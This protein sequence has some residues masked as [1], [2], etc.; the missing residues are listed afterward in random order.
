MYNLIFIKF[1]LISYILPF[2]GRSYYFVKFPGNDFV[3]QSA[4]ETIFIGFLIYLMI[5]LIRFIVFFIVSIVLLFHSQS[6]NKIFKHNSL[7]LFILF[8]LDNIILLI[9]IKF[10]IYKIYEFNLFEYAFAMILFS[11]SIS[12]LPFWLVF[13][14]RNLICLIK[15]KK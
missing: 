3:W 6:I 1:F 4:M 12:Y 11:L 15:N 8:I 9:S 7:I 2:L 14:V 13:G 5:Y 10:G